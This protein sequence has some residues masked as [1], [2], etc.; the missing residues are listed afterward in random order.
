MEQ[1]I[2]H[3]PLVL[4]FLPSVI[5]MLVQERHVARYKRRSPAAWAVSK[6]CNGEKKIA[7]PSRLYRHGWLQLLYPDSYHMTVSYEYDTAV[8]LLACCTILTRSQS[9]LIRFHEI[10]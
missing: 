10:T 4:L 9:K 7:S 5:R 8:V 6:L 2:G 1:W 3:E